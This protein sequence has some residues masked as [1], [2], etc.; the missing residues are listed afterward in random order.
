MLK[1]LYSKEVFAE[2][3]SE[4][5]LGVSISGCQIRCPE[6]HFLAL[7]IKIL[8]CEYLVLRDALGTLAVRVVGIGLPGA[9][10]DLRVVFVAEVPE[11]EEVTI[12]E[13]W[14]SWTWR[15]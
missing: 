13:A 7:Y 3:P 14:F 15:S 8:Q 10:V 5:T 2:V 1:Y 4:I 11:E 12:S 9:D 6:C